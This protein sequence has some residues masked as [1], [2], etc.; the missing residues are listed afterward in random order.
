MRAWYCPAWNGDHRLEA[1]GDGSV[2]VV[3]RPT[4]LEVEVLEDF[5]ALARERGWT[6]ARRIPRGASL[7]SRR[8][9]LDAPVAETGLEL[10]KLHRSDSARQTITA[11]RFGGGEVEVAAL[12]DEEATRELAAKGAADEESAAVSAKRP[13]PCCPDCEPGS[14]G[15][16][17]EVLL[18]FLTPQQHRDWSRY[19]VVSVEG[20][21]TGH[22]YLV[23]HRHTELAR[24]Q[25]R[26]CWDV[27]DG[28]LLH[29]YD[30]SMPPEE[31]VLAAVLVLRHR[32]SWLRNEATCLGGAGPRRHVL[33]NPFGDGGDGTETAAF[34]RAFG[35]H[36]VG[37]HE[38]RLRV[39]SDGF[40]V[41]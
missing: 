8:V 2:L 32:E 4:P 34:F 26:I 29:L 10:A 19:R 36:L 6:R 9:Y 25:T 3:R 39:N 17:R 40:L 13:T 33:K 18:A 30:W 14:I 41:G 12:D 21:T 7:V 16:A 35:E 38:G 1:S 23:A 31:E 20:G 28:A 27:D 5:L 22:R 11:V 24:R 37:R 15:P